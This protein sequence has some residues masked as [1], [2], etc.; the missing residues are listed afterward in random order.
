MVVLHTQKCFITRARV[1]FCLPPMLSKVAPAATKR[2]VAKSLASSFLMIS[3]VAIVFGKLEEVVWLRRRQP[4]V[5]MGWVPFSFGGC[6]RVSD[7]NGFMASKQV[8]LDT[9]GELIL[10]VISMSHLIFFDKGF[11]VMNIFKSNFLLHSNIRIPQQKS[12]LFPPRVPGSISG[13]KSR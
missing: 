1:S 7:A 12:L 5:G 4:V 6:K 8:S 13:L 11:L 10:Q 3:V 2:V 9:R